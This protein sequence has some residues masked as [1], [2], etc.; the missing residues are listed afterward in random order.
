MKIQ[1]ITLADE[2]DS[3]QSLAVK[4]E[5]VKFDA[6]K[7]SG[8]LNCLIISFARSFKKKKTKSA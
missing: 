1:Q 5:A 7:Q 4:P 2:L 6:N 3:K 8:L